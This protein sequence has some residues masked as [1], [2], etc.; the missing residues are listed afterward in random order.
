MAG[1]P[2]MHG[3]GTT[4]RETGG[5]A[6]AYSASSIDR[7]A[8]AAFVSAVSATLSLAG[9]CLVLIRVAAPIFLVLLLRTAGLAGTASLLGWLALHRDH[10]GPESAS[11]VRMAPIAIVIGRLVLG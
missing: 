4:D 10:A 6:D 8:V 11:G 2:N 1:A 3:G 5:I 7:I 9:F